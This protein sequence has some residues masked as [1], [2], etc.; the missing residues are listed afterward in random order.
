MKKFLMLSAVYLTV[1]SCVSKKKFTELESRHAQTVSNL[2]KTRIEKED[3]ENKFARIEARAAKYNERINSLVDEN[4]AKLDV[5]EGKLVLSEANKKK[6]RQVLSQM[7]AGELANAKTLTDSVNIAV[8]N[9]LMKSVD[10]SDLESS[11]DID[12]NIDDTVVVISISDKMLFKSGSF[13]VNSSANKILSK[14]ASVIN[15]EPSIEVLVEGHTDSQTINTIGIKD[16]WDLSVKR[17]TS[18]VR[19]LQE[20]YQ[21]EPAKL[22]AAGRSSYIPLTD[23]TTSENRSRNRRTEIKIL[24]KIDKFFALLGAE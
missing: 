17:A 1:I 15:S 23:N 20:K 6:M 5:I 10:T 8:S 4:D 22:I 21:V 14:I 24:P 3:L 16:N 11:D 12:I 9:N 19:L 7:D 2:Q 13:S 18:I